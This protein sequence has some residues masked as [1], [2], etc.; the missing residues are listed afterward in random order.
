MI[1]VRAAAERNINNA[2][3]KRPDREIR[4]VR[5]L[6]E[7]VRSVAVRYICRN[8]FTV[9]RV[10]ASDRSDYVGQCFLSVK[11]F[12][13]ISGNC[14][15]ADCMVLY[16]QKSFL[17]A[18]LVYIS[19]FVGQCFAV[20]MMPEV[21]YHSKLKTQ[22]LK[23]LDREYFNDIM[24]NNRTGKYEDRKSKIRESPREGAV[25]VRGSCEEAV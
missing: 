2:A 1:H 16:C 24:I 5:I 12:L 11:S 4:K 25:M 9:Y 13:V 15:Y 10:S 21:L 22:E 18:L 19:G 14:N 17:C 7:T 6:F 20:N 23:S 8:I 3:E